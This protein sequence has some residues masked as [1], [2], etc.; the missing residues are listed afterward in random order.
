VAATPP[1]SSTVAVVDDLRALRVHFFDLDSHADFLA[2]GR[3]RAEV[4][5]DAHADDAV[6]VGEPRDHS[7]VDGLLHRA[8]YLRGRGHLDAVGDLLRLEI[9][10][11]P[12]RFAYQSLSDRRE[13]AV[14]L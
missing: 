13:Q 1:S 4:A 2:N 7:V 12:R 8:D 6:A 5:L 3:R 9:S 14:A 10:D 11:L